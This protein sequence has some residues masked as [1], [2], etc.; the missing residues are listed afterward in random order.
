MASV[1]VDESTSQSS[2]VRRS[3]TSSQQARDLKLGLSSHAERS[4]P[5]RLF[6]PRPSRR[7]RLPPKA[8]PR[9]SSNS[10]AGTSTPSSRATPRGTTP[11]SLPEFECLCA[12]GSVVRRADFL[13]A[14]QRPMTNRSFL[15][16]QR[17]QSSCSATWLS[18]PR[19][20]RS[21]APT[22]PL[23][24]PATPTSGSSERDLDDASGADHAGTRTIERAASNRL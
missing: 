19:S 22:A 2:G 23:V 11:I 17:A 12:D 16:R 9:S 1:E 15:A 4:R 6:A 24:P 14:A 5:R 7:S 20:R 18:S 8:T 3:A 10:T 13:A 21:F